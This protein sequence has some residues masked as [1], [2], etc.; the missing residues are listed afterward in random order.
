MQLHVLN[1]DSFA[2]MILYKKGVKIK[3]VK[4]HIVGI[5]IKH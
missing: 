5:R 4:L 1:L 2:H 3:Y